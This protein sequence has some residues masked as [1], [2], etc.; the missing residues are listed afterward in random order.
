MGRAAGINGAALFV[1]LLFWTWMWGL[2]GTLVAVPLMM[3]IKTACERI[4]GLEAFGELLN[5]K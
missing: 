5:E 3:I 1:S 4:E 2:I